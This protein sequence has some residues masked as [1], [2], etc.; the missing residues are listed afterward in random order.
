MVVIG[1][2]C[3]VRGGDVQEN[4]LVCLKLIIDL[5]RNYRPPAP[6]HV[7]K[8]LLVFQRILRFF[9]LSLVHSV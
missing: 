2:R 1:G 4:A 8:F 7:K 6:D 9:P 5:Q 3:A